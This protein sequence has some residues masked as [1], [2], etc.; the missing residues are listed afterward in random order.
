MVGRGEREDINRAIE[1][2]MLTTKFY[3]DMTDLE[4]AVAG[5]EGKQRSLQLDYA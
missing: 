3:V 1:G 4:L 5:A 2:T